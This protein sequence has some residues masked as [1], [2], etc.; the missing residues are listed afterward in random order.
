MLAV[1]YSPTSM[2]NTFCD[3]SGHLK[4]HSTEKLCGFSTQIPMMKFNLQTSHSKR[5]AIITNNKLE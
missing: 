2:E 5:L 3:T 1:L 4:L